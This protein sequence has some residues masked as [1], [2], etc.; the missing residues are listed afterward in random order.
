MTNANFLIVSLL[1]LNL[2][3]TMYFGL[4]SNQ[5]V[6]N[7]RQQTSLHQLPDKITKKIRE[8]IFSD[9]KTFFNAK[10]YDSLYDMFGPVAKEQ[11]EKDQLSSAFDKLLSTFGEIKS[12]AFEYSE[13]T[14]NSGNIKGYA[15][16]Y[17]VSLKEGG[18]FGDAA[19]LKISI[20]VDK[21]E[22][23]IYGIH[24]NSTI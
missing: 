18:N 5:T 4:K 16:F 14:G 20:G 2:C 12:G 8:D 17:R 22:Y 21:D 1:I 9:F 7:D 23:E 11:I 10:D 13:F 15:L 3:T 6:Q 19:K 24:L